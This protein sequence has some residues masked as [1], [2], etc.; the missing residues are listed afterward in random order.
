MEKLHKVVFRFFELALSPL[1]FLV[2][3]FGAT[4][5]FSQ[6]EKRTEISALLNT[7]APSPQKVYLQMDKPSYMLG[8]T[9]WYKSYVFN[10]NYLNNQL[11]KEILY[12]EVVDENQN[13][14]K[15]QL[16]SQYYGMGLGSITLSDKSYRAGNY[17]I[18]AYTNWMRNFEAKYFFERSFTIT[19]PAS[20]ELLVRS[21]MIVQNQGSEKTVN[22]SLQ[23]TEVTGAQMASN[24]IELS[25]LDG[26]KLRKKVQLK[27]DATGTLNF[28]FP[29]TNNDAKNLSIQLK[30]IGNDKIQDLRFP[31]I[32]KQEKNIDL[33]FLPEAGNLLIGIR[34][35]IA[36]KA[37]GEDGLGAEVSGIIYNNLQQAITK[38]NTSH[39]GMGSFYLTPKIGEVYTAVVKQQDG[40]QQSYPLPLAKK[41]GVMFNVINNYLSDSLLV[42][43]LA[44]ADK[45]GSNYFFIGQARGIGCYG[46]LVKVTDSILTIKISK[47]LFP[48]G[49]AKFVLLDEQ[50]QAIAERLVFNIKDD[51]LKV[52]IKANKVDYKNKDSVDLNITVKDAKGNPVQGGFSVAVTDDN[53]VEIDSIKNEN[54]L[55]RIL[56]ISELQGYIEDPGYYFQ[57]QMTT[58]VW[59]DLDCLLLA[60]GWK[61][62]NWNVQYS[63]AASTAFKHEMAYTISGKVSNIVNKPISQANIVLLSKKPSVLL[64]TVSNA[65]GVFTFDNLKPADS[66]IYFIQARNKNNKS[67]NV[68]IQ[69]DDFVAPKF[70]TI[71]HLVKPWFL[72]V[73]TSTLD[74]LKNRVE[75]TEEQNKLLGKKLREV[76]I[77]GKKVVKDSKN[78]NGAGEADISLNSEDLEKAGKKTLGEILFEKVPNFRTH[79]INQVYVI[80]DQLV[81]LIIDGVSIDFARPEGMSYRDYVKDYLDFITAQDIKGIE[82]MNSPGRIKN[83]GVRFLKADENV[84]FNCFIEI[85]TYSGNGAFMNKTPGVYLFRPMSIAS[86]PQFYS[87]KYKVKSNQNLIDARSTVY[88]NPNVVTDRNGLAHIGFYTTDKKGTY[89]ILFEGS[90]MNG[91]IGSMRSKIVVK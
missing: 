74:I 54:L 26:K 81:H 15:R 27:T 47:S 79:G 36:F 55:S 2:L 29:I 13:L 7:I 89:T 61:S 23:L 69:M 85:T 86:A 16:V 32:L 82:V 8:D 91:A 90:D 72:N 67:F 6:T 56:L 35:K 60:Q 14:V 37:I 53:Q 77:V 12:V 42:N 9:L 40:S 43:I 19:V 3:L 51:Y 76:V 18:R 62:Y 45:R 83:Y 57:K 24:E 88:W 84:D 4:Q 78:L 71:N 73:D 10:T 28:Q 25:L 70:N 48:S 39:L 75:N 33:Q 38:F 80:R 17:V 20:N 64:Q 52:N 30:T 63:K 44:T 50:K 58:K 46:G 65:N 22:A 1:L 5:V 49:I 31:V 66:A 68:G 87:P 11:A 41:S 59:Q 34:S 21:K